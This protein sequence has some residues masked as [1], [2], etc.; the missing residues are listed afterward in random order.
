MKLFFIA[1]HSRR[2]IRAKEVNSI[3]GFSI[4]LERPVKLCFK[5]YNKFGRAIGRF[6]QVFTHVLK[7]AVNAKFFSVFSH[8]ALLVGF[9]GLHMAAN[10]S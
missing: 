8:C 4:R 9:A 2:L 5:Y 3:N 10:G 1:D 7:A 6:I